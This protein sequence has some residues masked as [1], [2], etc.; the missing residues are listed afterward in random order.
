MTSSPRWPTPAAPRPRTSLDDALR[1]AIAS[2]V[3]IVD[4]DGR[5]AEGYAFRHAL[6]AEVAYDELL[7]GERRRLHR[8][9]AEAI[10]L[11]PAPPGASAAAHWAE[12]AH[13]WAR[14]HEDERAFEASLNAATA[15]EQAF[16]FGAAFHQLERVL[17]LWPGLPDAE[18]LA[19]TDQAEILTRA[20]EMANLGGDAGPQRGPAPRGDRQPRSL[21]GPIREAVMHEQL[22]RALWAQGESAEALVEHERAMAIMPADP[23]TAERA[24]VLA[25][26]GQ[27]LMLLDRWEASRDLCQEAIDIALQVGAREAEGHA[28]NTLGLDLAAQGDCERAIAELE[29]GLAIALEVGNIDDVG[30]AH[31]N[32]SEA[33]NFCGF[34]ERSAAAVEDGDPSSGRVRHRHVLRRLH[35]PQR[36]HGQLRPGPMGSRGHAC[37]RECRQRAGRH[38]HRRPVPDQPLD[39]ATRCDRRVRCREGAARAAWRSC[40][41]GVP[42]R[43]AVQRQLLRGDGR[44]RPLGGPPGRRP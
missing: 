30:R 14:A 32:L 7:P 42:S 15:A 1:A 2:Q 18:R 5:G 16:A 13:H 29:S 34:P 35:P 37:C 8:A 11:R 33:L 40:I 20:A 44:A 17:D 24:R 43:G 41:E 27:I 6:L 21:R 23:P 4:M 12:L 3:L 31:V 36:D 19:G 26:Y 10:A 39:S 9:C 22:G 38:D 25:G 28:R